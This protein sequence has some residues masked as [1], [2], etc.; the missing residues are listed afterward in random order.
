M[1]RPRE[2]H[3]LRLEKCAF[4]ISIPHRL[5]WIRELHE[6]N[7]GHI[8]FTEH[9]SE[10][11]IEAEF[12]LDVIESNPFNF[13][14]DPEA[15]EYPF[16]YEA[17]LYTELHALSRNIYERDVDLIRDWLHPVWHPGK[18][19]GTLEL[20]QQLNTHI[21]STLKYQRRLEKGV[22]SPAETLEKKSGSCRDFAT[23]FMEACRYLGIAS[24]FVSG[25]MYS[26]DING[27]M[28]MHGWA[29]VY[30]PGAGWIGFDPSWGILASSHYFPVA[31][32]RYSENVPPISGTYTGTRRDFLRTDVDLYVTRLSAYL[33]T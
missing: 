21:Y 28:S 8:D 17:E 5:R 2:S 25:Y 1:M 7:I 23:L 3:S 32:S 30:L 20:L 22:Q 4:T 26:P 18:R 24:R 19:L 11:V 12:I 9:A 29:E 10:L 33:L 31:V 15:A 13:V 16:S 27:R 6:N 14:I